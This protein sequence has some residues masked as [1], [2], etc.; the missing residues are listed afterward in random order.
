MCL[1]AHAGVDK[2]LSAEQE[3]QSV[4]LTHFVEDSLYYGLFYHRWIQSSVRLGC[5]ARA[6]SA[7]HDMGRVL[8]P[9][10][11]PVISDRLSVRALH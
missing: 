7:A 8:W 5:S 4:M 9:S 6:A 11:G 3:A 10:A 1:P 2:P